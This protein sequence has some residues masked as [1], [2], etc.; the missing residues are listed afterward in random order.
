MGLLDKIK[1]LFV[2]EHPAPTKPKNID[3]TNQNILKFN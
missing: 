2:G 1:K 3:S